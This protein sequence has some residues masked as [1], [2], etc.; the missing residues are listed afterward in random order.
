ML[1]RV[2]SVVVLAGA[3]ACVTSGCDRLN[4]DWC[5]EKATCAADEY[6]DPGTNT[7]RPREAGVKPDTTPKTDAVDLE[8]D[9]DL[10]VNDRG[11]DVPVKPDLAPDLPPPDQ[12]PPDLPPAKPDLAPTG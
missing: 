7:C 11:S 9:P 10:P 12:G 2:A 5:E 6:C 4:P 1:A 3:C 8:G